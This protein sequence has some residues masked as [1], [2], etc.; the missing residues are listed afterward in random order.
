MA[1]LF[2]IIKSTLYLIKIHVICF[3]QSDA[4]KAESKIQV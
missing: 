4:F 2:Q 1:Y 3:G